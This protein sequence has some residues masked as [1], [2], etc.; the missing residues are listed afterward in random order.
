MH[1][2]FIQLAT[3]IRPRLIALCRS[4]FDT[5]E[6]A[7]DAEDA[8]QETLLRLWMMYE[9]VGEYRS[10]ETLAV[11]IAKNVCID[12]LKKA[13]AQHQSLDNA[14]IVFAPVQT[15]HQAIFHDTERII[16][17]AMEKLSGKQRRM[18]IMRSEGM[19]IEEIATACGTTPASAKT[20]ICVARKQ[21]LTTISKRRTKK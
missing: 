10:P 13:C 5:Q 11:K 18:L 21:L 9:R 17:R 19:T 3:A 15:D 8:V 16:G 4:F 1:N 7:C 14:T 6:L 2:D 20:M 12:F